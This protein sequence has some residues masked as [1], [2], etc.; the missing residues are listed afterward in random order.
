MIFPE[1]VC[2]RERLATTLR[3]K[4]NLEPSAPKSTA[5]PIELNDISTRTTKSMISEWS[6]F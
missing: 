4:W 2:T 6:G 5:L 1:F 3:K